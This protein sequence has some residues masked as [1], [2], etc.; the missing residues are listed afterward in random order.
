MSPRLERLTS[1]VVLITSLGFKPVITGYRKREDMSNRHMS[2]SQ[3]AG[4][5][6]PPPVNMPDLV[7][8]RWA[9]SFYL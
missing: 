2:P 5:P 7:K 6:F 1:F 9:L 4:P 8:P 3:E